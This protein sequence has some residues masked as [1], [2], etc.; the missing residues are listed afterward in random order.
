MNG[1]GAHCD[2][3]GTQHGDYHAGAA[4][5]PFVFRG[6]GDCLYVRPYAQQ[7]AGYIFDVKTAP[8]HRLDTHRHQGPI[9]GHAAG[10]HRQ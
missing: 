5:R 2:A 10:G 4:V 3:A 7:T 9:S 8:A 6:L 1:T